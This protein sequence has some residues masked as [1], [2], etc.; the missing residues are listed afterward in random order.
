[1]MA[2]D[3][4]S[5]RAGR[6]GFAEDGEIIQVRV[7]HHRATRSF[8]FLEHGFEAHDVR[9]FV[10]TLRAQT[11]PQQRVRELPLLGRHFLDGQSLPYFGNEK[12]VAALV[13]LEIK[14]G[15]RTLFGRE[16]VEK[17]V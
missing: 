6:F 15:S 9:G 17:S 1:M 7:A 4:P 14:R 13:V 10:V 5:P 8:E 3:A 16:R 2:F 11:T 12:P